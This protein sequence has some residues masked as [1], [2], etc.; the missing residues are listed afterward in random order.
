MNRNILCVLNWKSTLRAKLEKYLS[1]LVEDCASVECEDGPPAA[2]AAAAP[3]KNLKQDCAFDFFGYDNQ[4]T[5]VS[6][7]KS[8]FDAHMASTNSLPHD[9]DPLQYWRGKSGPLSK[10][11]LQILSVPA[12]SA[13]VERIFSHAGLIVTAKRTRMADDLLSALVKANVVQGDEEEGSNDDRFFVPGL[14]DGDF[15][16]DDDAEDI[17]EDEM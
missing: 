14:E 16:D 2:A 6:D 17:V 8:M 15:V 7:W 11:A 3:S 12:S 10:I 1:V 9:M 4:P 13:P 5:K